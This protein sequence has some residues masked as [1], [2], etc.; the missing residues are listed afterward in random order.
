M[1]RVVPVDAGVNG[2]H[3]TSGLAAASQARAGTGR[4]AMERGHRRSG[5]AGARVRAALPVAWAAGP[6]GVT[7][8]VPRGV[9]LAVLCQVVSR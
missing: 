6:A 8:W 9:Q 4:I 7:R 1:H 3:P 5:V 2:Q